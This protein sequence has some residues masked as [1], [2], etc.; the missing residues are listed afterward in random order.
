VVAVVLVAHAAGGWYFSGRIDSQ[1]LGVT[2][3]TMT[4]AHDDARVVAVKGDLVTLSRG[5]DAASN[6][7]A[8]ASYGMAWDGGTGHVGPAVVNADDTV[9]RSLDVV[10]GVAPKAGQDAAI[11]R[12]Y[13]L[14]D[15]S[16]TLGLQFSDVTIAGMP[17]WWV[18]AAATSSGA[19]PRT[20]AVF[21]H[22]RNG[23]RL[24]G[25]RFVAPAHRSGAPTLVIS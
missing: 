14:G 12:A 25:L 24:A 11:E 13:F 10:S 20:A 19:T 21:V 4:P 18:P 2:P 6:F 9:T 8:P 15:P 7:G 22:G 5:V 23:T 17:A 16:T 3:G 1:A